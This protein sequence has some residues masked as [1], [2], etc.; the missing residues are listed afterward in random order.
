MSWRLDSSA[1]VDT[2]YSS[3]YIFF[4][5]YK[6]GNF[7]NFLLFYYKYKDDYL[8]LFAVWSTTAESVLLELSV[9]VIVSS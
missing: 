1:T 2:D 4:V 7:Y 6:I 8:I 5:F 3:G 9:F